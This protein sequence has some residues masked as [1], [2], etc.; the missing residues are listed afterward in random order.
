LNAGAAGAVGV[1]GAI[2]Q[3]TSLNTLTLTHSNG[4]TFSAPVTADTAVV[5]TN[6]TA[7][8]TIR[9]ANNLTTGALTT[10]GNAYNLA[11]VGGTTQVTAA[12]TFLNTGTLTLGDAA[13]DSLAFVGGL[14]ATAPSSLSLGGTVA[15]TNAAMTL[16][17]SDTAL[18]LND[19]LTLSS[20]NAALTLGGLVY[21]THDLTLNS[22]GVTTLTSTVGGN[23]Q[24]LTSLTTNA[25]GSVVIN[26]GAVTTSGEQTYGESLRVS[27]GMDTTLTA[28][29]VTFNAP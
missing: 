20:G 15:T 22:T 27:L 8:Q 26:G 29:R 5:L 10:T 11:L 19:N 4:A 18:V 12:T 25:G 14:V 9:F 28:S 17:D 3:T 6:T 7:G 16:G 23:G 21:G 13:T 1:T 2:G 24:A